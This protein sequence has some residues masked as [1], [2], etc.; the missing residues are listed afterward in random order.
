MKSILILD[1]N[2]EIL[3]TLKRVFPEYHF[4]RSSDQVRDDRQLQQIFSV[5][6][7]IMINGTL[8][9]KPE[10]EHI[11]QT[12]EQTQ[13]NC[14]LFKSI[15]SGPAFETPYITHLQLPL[16]MDDLQS[17]LWSMLEESH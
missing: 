11:K 8:Y 15:S 7:L 5:M 12:L 1:R 4:Y 9:G 10:L 17:Y 16:D 13:T 6:D 14:L 3:D 2:T